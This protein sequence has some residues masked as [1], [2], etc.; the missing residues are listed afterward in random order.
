MKLED[1]LDEEFK[2]LGVEVR[3]RH[4][5]PDKYVKGAVSAVTIATV[6]NID[7]N[8]VMWNWR[9]PN[10]YNRRMAYIM[11]SRISEVYP[12]V[13]VCRT[14]KSKKTRRIIA[15]GRLLKALRAERQMTDTSCLRVHCSICGAGV[16]VP[17]KESVECQKCGHKIPPVFVVKSEET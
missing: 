4:L 15:K 2:L 5:L 7:L 16:C 13:A 9:D 6:G 8:R 3:V 1:Y 11:C 17:V 12:G 10:V 14:P